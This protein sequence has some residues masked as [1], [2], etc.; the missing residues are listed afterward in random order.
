MH[1]RGER[2]RETWKRR[3]RAAVKRLGGAGGR[4]RTCDSHTRKK[5]SPIDRA[6]EGCDFPHRPRSQFRAP[7]FGGSWACV[8][9]SAALHDAT[10]HV[11]V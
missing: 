10:W 5:H 2:L 3:Y 4:R 8:G 6:R 7:G 11:M 1:G 9:A